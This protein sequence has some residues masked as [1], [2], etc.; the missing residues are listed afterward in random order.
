M[1]SSNAGVDTFG[2]KKLYVDNT[3]KA[4]E[5]WVMGNMLNDSRIRV[6]GTITDKGGGEWEGHVTSADN[7]AS[8]RINVNTTNP[9]AMDPNTQSIL[10]TDWRKMLAAGYMVDAKDW[11]NIEM[12]IYWKVLSW[13][14][15]DEMSLYARGGR[16]SSGWP[17]GCLGPCYKG[18]IQKAGNSRWAKEYHHYAGS[19]GYWFTAGHN[20][21][22]LSDRTN[23]WTGQKVVMYDKTVNGKPVVRLEVW[24]E[25]SDEAN[26]NPTTQNWQMINW[27]ED[28]GTNTQDPSDTGFIS[29]CHGVSKQQF[30]WGGPTATFRIDNVIVRVKKAS[31]RHIVGE[32]TGTTPPPTFPTGQHFDD[33][34]GICV[35]DNI[36]NPP[37][38]PPTDSGQPIDY[39]KFYL[40]GTTTNNS[41]PFQS[42]GGPISNVEIQPNA[43]QNLFEDLSA[44]SQRTGLKSNRVIYAKNTSATT[45]LP[46]TRVFFNEV[47]NYTKVALGTAAINGTESTIITEDPGTGTTNPPG[48]G[49]GS[50]QHYY[51]IYNTGISQSNAATEKLDNTYSKIANHF[52]GTNNPA[53][54]SKP[55]RFTVFG[56]KVG[57]PTGNMTAK[58]LDSANAVKLSFPTIINVA[59]LTTSV[60]LQQIQFTIPDNPNITLASGDRI[61]VEYSGGTATNYV[62]I[63]VVKDLQHIPAIECQKWNG[64]TW[65]T[66]A[67]STTNL[68]LSSSL[69]DQ[70]TDLSLNAL[71]RITSPGLFKD[72]GGIVL[73]NAKV[74]LIYWGTNSSKAYLDVRFQAMLAAPYFSKLRQYASIQPPTFFA[75]YTNTRTAVKDFT[76]TDLLKCVTDTIADHPEI[77]PSATSVSQPFLY[78]VIPNGTAKITDVPGA[79]GYHTWA[80]STYGRLYFT[81]VGAYTHDNL[82]LDYVTAGMSHEIYE[83]VV[84]AEYPTGIV[85]PAPGFLS[86]Y[87]EIG[88]ICTGQGDPNPSNPVGFPG[89]LGVYSDYITGPSGQTVLVAEYYSN[90]DGKC[91]IPTVD[92]NPNDPSAPTTTAII[93]SVEALATSG[94]GTIPSGFMVDHGGPIMRTMQIQ[95]IFWG[96]AW[97][98]QSKPYTKNNII[99]AIQS[100][101]ASPY[102]SKMRQYKGILP[103]TYLGQITDTKNTTY[104]LQGLFDMTWS[105]ILDGT[106]PDFRTNSNVAYYVFLPN[107]KSIFGAEAQGFHTSAVLP[108]AN[109]ALFVIMMANPH[110]DLDGIMGTVS[111]EIAEA[112]TDPNTDPTHGG[113]L[114]PTHCVIE[115]PGF[116]EISDVCDVVNA[117][118]GNCDIDFSREART[119]GGILCEPYWSNAD[120]GCVVP[121]SDDG[122]FPISTDVQF[123]SVLEIVAGAGSLNLASAGFIAIDDQ[124]SKICVHVWGTTAV[125][126]NQ[127]I[128]KIE[129]F[130]KKV[131]NPTGSIHLGYMQA[132]KLSPELNT[133]IEGGYHEVFAYENAPGDSSLDVSTLSTAYTKVT[134]T[135]PETIPDYEPQINDA[136]MWI[137]SG[138]SGNN[139][140]VMATG[141]SFNFNTAPGLFVGMNLEWYNNDIDPV[142]WHNFQ[143]VNLDFSNNP[144]G[145]FYIDSTLCFG[146]G[147]GGGTTPPPGSGGGGGIVLAQPQTYETGLI[148]GTLNPSD[149]KSLILQRNVPANAIESA[150]TEVE[151]IVSAGGTAASGGGGTPIPCPSGQ[152]YDSTLNTCVP[153][154]INTPPPVG[155]CTNSIYPGTGNKM[156]AT[157]TGATTRHY[158]SDGSSPTTER[159]VS[160]CPFENYEMTAYMNIPSD[161]A[162]FKM[163]GPNHTDSTCC[164]YLTVVASNGDCSFGYEQPHPST[165]LN[166]FKGP[167]IGNVGSK[168]IG[169]KAVIWKL[170]TGNGA[171]VELWTDTAGKWVKQLSAD[172]PCGKVFTKAS[173]QQVLFRID[174]RPVT[175]NCA[176]VVEI[177]PNPSSVSA[178]AFVYPTAQDTFN[179]APG[180]SGDPT[181]ALGSESDE[182]ANTVS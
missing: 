126:Y 179:L 87:T 90:I 72:R 106:V 66:V 8:F 121:T 85:A 17:A 86:G 81:C 43:F 96:A 57:T 26:G 164:W 113:I 97:N 60:D 103:P 49:T 2:V 138:M 33:I 128:V 116:D 59:S 76:A 143:P 75:S 6:D 46:D 160:N 112:Q 38:P 141:D 91:V 166:C 178:T 174:A 64:S 44:A 124:H 31:V 56:R 7:P 181:N 114:A 118:G 100:L 68:T 148:I 13:S 150:D 127:R 36:S 24:K 83:S 55:L 48:T 47:D 20:T 67:T 10:G 125:I 58:I 21:S 101:I 107:G 23:V 130:L 129:V 62:E 175:F 84:D 153:D 156:T 40:S 27:L 135:R 180:A 63:A 16:H 154:V 171:H 19:T 167:N 71:T 105:H 177:K 95:L 162:T 123:K 145:A 14:D 159:A 133:Y 94:I 158:A 69:P 151:L 144:A 182:E 80:N 34:L 110:D 42:L 122:S 3:A 39:L 35:Q 77:K 5:N 28:D 12:T 88:D 137:G 163:W 37:P 41:N 108:E 70:N 78:C 140:V 172:N 50:I 61:D 51:A 111:H 22:S 152:H 82:H 173:G 139:Y 25:T 161:T 11:R 79:G 73:S 9:N 131:G 18:Q 134:F 157:D 52:T 115:S 65:S 146:S 98:T 155:S 120:S 149:Y 168:V 29:N 169:I 53:I 1:S 99:S 45:A 93:G 147:G 54:G 176:E 15:A 132:S 136:L 104:T 109:N 4:S 89:P 102:F 142:N 165:N 117:Q 74:V 30:L 92:Y 119:L 170:A 32:G